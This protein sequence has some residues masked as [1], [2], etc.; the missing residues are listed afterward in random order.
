MKMIANDS[1]NFTLRF[2]SLSKNFAPKKQNLMHKISL[3]GGKSK[4]YT[5][6]RFNI[7]MF[8]IITFWG[9]WIVDCWMEGL[10]CWWKSFAVFSYLRLIIQS[11]SISLCKNLQLQHF[12]IVFSKIFHENG[13]KHQEMIFHFACQWIIYEAWAQ[14]ATD[15]VRETGREIWWMKCNRQNMISL[16]T[17][18][19][20]L[21]IRSIQFEFLIPNKWKKKN[22]S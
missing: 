14:R 9:L 15:G 20:F 6:T 7:S 13:E 12:S 3:E 16:L 10:S 19:L 8:K 17:V 21:F 4:R 18:L 2:S 1:I 11:K 5:Q 22:I